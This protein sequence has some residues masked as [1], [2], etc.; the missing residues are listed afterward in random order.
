MITTLHEAHKADVIDNLRSIVSATPPLQ[1]STQCN[2]EDEKLVWYSTYLKERHLH[3]HI[4]VASNKWLPSPTQKIFNLAIIKKAKIQ[5]GSVDDEFVHETIRGQVDNILSKKSPIELENIFKN[6]DGERNVILIDGA[7]GSGKSTLMVHICQR[8][9]R[10]ELF[11][12]FNVIILVQLRDPAVQS[13]QTIAELLPCR[14]NEMAHQVAKAISANDGRGVLWILDGWDELPSH[15]RKKSLLRDMITPP[16]ISPVTQSSV[17]I[18]SRPVSSGDLSEL[19]S[20]RIEV[21]GFTLEEQRQYF[22]ECL[23]GDTKAVETLVERLNEN[24]AIEGSCSLPLNASIVAHLYLSDG[25]LPTTIHGIVSSLVQHH[26]SRYLCERLGK[27]QNEASFKSVSDIPQELQ[28]PFDQLCKL[29]FMGTKE[30]KVAFSCRDLE[31]IKDSA[32]VFEMGLLRATPSML[33]NHKLNFYNFLHLSIQEFLAAVYISHMPASEQISTFD[34]L[35]DDS[36]FSAVLQFYAAITKLRTSRLFLSKLPYLLRPVPAGV[37]DVVKKIVYK[38]KHEWG[39]SIIIP[40]LHCLYEAQDPSLCEFVAKELKGRLYLRRIGVNIVDAIAIGYFLSSISLTSCGSKEFIVQLIDCPLQDSGTKSLMQSICKSIGPHHTVN[41]HL[42]LYLYANLICEEGASY[43]AKVLSNTNVINKLVISFGK[44]GPNP[45]GGKGFQFISQALITNSS[46]SELYL[47]RCSLKITEENGPTL[48]EMLQRNKTLKTLRLHSVTEDGVS[49]TAAFFIAEGL[50]MNTAL[51]TL[52]LRYCSIHSSGAEDLSRAVVLNVVMEELNIGYNA[53]GDEGVAHLSEALK[54][55]KTLKVLNV[56][57]CKMT[58]NGVAS[59]ADALLINNTLK[60]LH[61]DSNWFG[62]KGIALLSKYIKQNKMLKYLGIS[63]CNMTDTGLASLFVALCMNNTL[64]RL[65]I[66][67]NNA[68]TKHGVIC[69]AE[70]FSKNSGL[71]ELQLPQPL[72]ADSEVRRTITE[73]RKRTGLAAIS[74]PEHVPQM[75]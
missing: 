10:G 60:E 65:N 20:S 48:T 53:I 30:N 38:Q 7:P 9:S 21:L 32:V 4:T 33:S 51:K 71:V 69:S 59:L 2:S 27:A 62:D 52:D 3:V 70:A 5:R 41:T 35:F 8:W 61:I 17:I 24:P 36:R 18:T 56:S 29:A 23:K 66:R 43:I 39:T 55:N 25:S 63:S 15:L 45:I 49:D 68:L 22:T 73:V 11:Q 12:E 42:D 13:A 72:R 16:N 44:G 46:L 28:A 40:L 47:S 26:L 6:I 14:D 57:S 54:Q 75:D 50:K 64:E 19:V 74:V 34:S 58:D 67:S 1:E 37:L 31:A